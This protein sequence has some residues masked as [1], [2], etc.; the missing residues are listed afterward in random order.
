M[1]ASSSKVIPWPPVRKTP[2][3]TPPHERKLFRGSS[4]FPTFTLNNILQ[5]PPPPVVNPKDAPRRLIFFTPILFGYMS[6]RDATVLRLVCRKLRAAV[7]A[8]PWKDEQTRVSGLV[9]HWRTSFPHAIAINISC[10]RALTD[11]EFVHLQ[12][13]EIIS[14]SMI[15]VRGLSAPLPAPPLTTSSTNKPPRNHAFTDTGLATYLHSVRKLDVSFCEHLTDKAFAN[16]PHL[17]QLNLSFL[18][19]KRLTDKAII[20]K[21]LLRRLSISGCTHITDAALVDL[22]LLEELNV[23]HCPLLTDDAFIHLT[24]LRGLRSCW[25]TQLTDEAYARAPFQHVEQLD[26]SF[27]PRLTSGAFISLS[28]DIHVRIKATG[29]SPSAIAAA[30]NGGQLPSHHCYYCC[31]IM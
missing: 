28:P 12:G 25:N 4:F 19:R 3:V 2:L 14:L 11:G 6:T 13:L 1:S 29:C 5:T 23:S 17:E 16:M 21:L 27:N 7:T 9:Y 22:P 31:P 15:D 30:K 20:G 10:R 18:N 24:K 8:F 26:I